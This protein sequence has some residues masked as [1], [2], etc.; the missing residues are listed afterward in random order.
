MHTNSA[1]AW[2]SKIQFDDF[3]ANAKSTTL[4]PTSETGRFVFPIDLVI[5]DSFP[6]L[7]ALTE[8]S[9]LGCPVA[10][11]LKDVLTSADVQ[12]QLDDDIGDF[13]GRFIPFKMVFE[14]AWGM[15][16]SFIHAGNS[17]LDALR[18]SLHLDT[19]EGSSRDKSPPFYIVCRV[20]DSPDNRAVCDW[21]GI[22]RPQ[23]LLKTSD[24]SALSWVKDQL[25]NCDAGRGAHQPHCG[26]DHIR[27]FLPSRLIDIRNTPFAVVC[28]ADILASLL[29]GA[30]P[31][32]YGALSY[33]WGSSHDA[34][35]QL[36]LRKASLVDGRFA[37]K[38]QDLPVVIREAVAVAR[39]L[40]L[41]YLWVDALCILQDD[42]S[43]W[44]A[45]SSQMG[46]I[47]GGSYITIG[48]LTP[49]CN[50]SFLNPEVPQTNIDF[51]SKINPNVRGQYSISLYYC[52]HLG[53]GANIVS[54]RLMQSR[55]SRRGWTLQES[56][57]SARLLCYEE[58]NIS[59]R[60]SD[61]T[62]Y[63]SGFGEPYNTG[64]ALRMIALSGQVEDAPI[65]DFWYDWAVVN[66][67]VRKFTRQDDVF[68]ALSG[69]AEHFN[70]S[71]GAKYIAGIW[72]RDL[73]TGLMWGAR[74][75]RDDLV[76]LR[77]SYEPTTLSALMTKLKAKPYVSPSWSWAGRQA[78][79][80]R[81]L[82]IGY[83][84]FWKDVCDE[85]ELIA[86]V[87]VTGTNPFG[88]VKNASITFNGALAA[89]EPCSPLYPMSNLRFEGYYRVALENGGYAACCF[90]WYI[91]DR[92]LHGEV[93]LVLLGSFV[94][95]LETHRPDPFQ[96]STTDSSSEDSEEERLDQD[97][98]D[99]AQ[100]SAGGS[101]S[102]DSGRAGFGLIVHQD[103]E[104]D[105]FL[106]VG[107][108][109]S[110]VSLGG[111]VRYLKSNE[112]Q[113]IVII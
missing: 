1:C 69:V 30:P 51:R 85:C 29:P 39:S 113:T 5:Y 47:Y 28:R 12:Y 4:T 18:I 27:A 98:P 72:E 15:L 6:G 110:L 52:T 60:C 83:S 2:C 67:C 56:L 7:P 63:L 41:G 40:S 101:P 76:G 71:F 102:G 38:F 16:E 58:S 23:S 3:A 73:T 37:F 106:R 11:F 70:K 55:W 42:E 36:S 31:P 94:E 109:Y 61:E 104:S 32:R 92:V 99:S 33:C 78:W 105:A 54:P 13:K 74:Q 79:I 95:D 22:E 97:N 45:E 112:T 14:Y 68:P 108:F 10:G 86:S 103:P 9:S 46:Q 81:P 44:E 21:L 66:Y 53:G 107:I 77:K 17:G 59:L 62:R 48:S 90:D 8:A 100:P 75:E 87:S 80:Q 35:R 24:D 25:S 49:S 89:V 65:S 50:I 43:D 82:L 57:L 20:H 91:D 93:K 96:A 26:L 84:Y 111:G 19:T 88:R 64:S 34:S